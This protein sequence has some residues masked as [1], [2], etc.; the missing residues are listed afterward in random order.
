MILT[1]KMKD[2]MIQ[3]SECDRETVWDRIEQT[4]RKENVAGWTVSGVNQ[5]LL[6][7]S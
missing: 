7:A 1:I 3:T 5:E 2:G 6:Q 4:G